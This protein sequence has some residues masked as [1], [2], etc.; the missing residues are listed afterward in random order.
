MRNLG[1]TREISELALNHVLKGVEAI[2]DVREDIPER[3]VA[4]ERWANFITHCEAIA[5]AA[6]E[7][8]PFD[9]RLQQEAHPFLGG[10]W[11]ESSSKA[12][13]ASPCT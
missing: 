2:Y 7:H 5:N 13:A 6:P 10:Q 9:G 1:V 8:G 4:L 11:M 3:R 12:D